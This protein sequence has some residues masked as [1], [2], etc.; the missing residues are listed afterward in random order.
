MELRERRLAIQSVAGTVALRLLAELV[1]HFSPVLAVILG[2]PS[3]IH[4][5]RILDAAHFRI[6]E[7][8][9]VAVDGSVDLQPFLSAI[10]TAR[11]GEVVLLQGCYHNPTGAALTGAD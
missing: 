2:T 8:P 4:Y 7:V 9:F 1:Q 11:P 3:H 10:R 5:R 6:D